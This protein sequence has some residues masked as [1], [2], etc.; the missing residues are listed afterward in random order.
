MSIEF[1]CPKCGKQIRAPESA[2]GKRGKCPYCKNSAYIPSPPDEGEEIGLAPLDEDA[3]ARDRR[4]RQEARDL[5]SALN[6]E[7]PGKYD[8]G[9]PTPSAGD[10]VLALPQDFESDLATQVNDYLQAM[11]GSDMGAADQ[12]TRQL[13][14]QGAQ[15]KKYVQ[16]LMQDGV[17]PANLG[18]PAP[19]FKGFLRSLLEML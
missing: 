4:L 5:A 11:T 2:G 17:P 13:K 14:K 6:R 19:V 12:A 10:S 7:E 1:D 9:D 15:A 3:E 16:R 18:V 8:T